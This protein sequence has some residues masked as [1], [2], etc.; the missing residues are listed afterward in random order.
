MEF[1]DECMIK[2]ARYFLK[3]SIQ[4]PSTH[5][6]DSQGAQQISNHRYGFK[7]YSNNLPQKTESFTFLYLNVCF[8]KEKTRV[9]L[10]YSLKIIHFPHVPSAAK[11]RFLGGPFFL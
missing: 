3:L 4:Y 2:L 10:F 9:L 7:Q 5:R 8:L 6:R 11:S 1:H